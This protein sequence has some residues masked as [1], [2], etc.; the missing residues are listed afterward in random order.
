MEPEPGSLTLSREPR[1]V[2]AIL[3]RFGGSLEV[4]KLPSPPPVD[5]DVDKAK[6]TRSMLMKGKWLSE[7]TNS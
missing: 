4:W 6:S 2:E 7:R 1:G 5:V 3:E